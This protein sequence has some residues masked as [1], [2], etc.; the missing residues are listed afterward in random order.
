MKA[1]I[2]TRAWEIARAAY[3]KFGGDGVKSYFSESLKMAWAE[4]RTKKCFTGY[5]VVEYAGN[6]WHFKGWTGGS[7]RRIYVSRRNR[8]SAGYIDLNNN[9]ETVCGY[10]VEDEAMQLFLSL[11][12]VA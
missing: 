4:T 6:D 7:K 1:N 12:A 3:N 10:A 8:Q 2:M 9:C 5:A 11:Y